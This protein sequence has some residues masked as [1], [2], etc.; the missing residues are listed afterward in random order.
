M[1]QWTAVFGCGVRGDA[2]PAPCR[3]LQ[4]G[5]FRVRCRP[6]KGGQ[7]VEF[8]VALPADRGTSRQK[9]RN[10]EVYNNQN[11][12][13]RFVRLQ[14][15]DPGRRV[16]S[17]ADQTMRAT[18]RLLMPAELSLSRNRNAEEE[19]RT[20]NQIWSLTRSAMVTFVSLVKA[21]GACAY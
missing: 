9:H 21:G 13:S 3:R 12:F 4:P 14:T 1:S 10:N 7:D 6:D 5:L 2:R 19:T 8:N 18:A 11:S 17:P 16:F 20:P 15:G